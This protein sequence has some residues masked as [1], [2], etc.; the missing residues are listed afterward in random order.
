MSAAAALRAVSGLGTPRRCPARFRPSPLPR[1]GSV[2][3]CAPC[4]R[5]G[6]YEH[7]SASSLEA[8]ALSSARLRRAKPSGLGR[9]QTRERERIEALRKAAGPCQSRVGSRA[10][11]RLRPTARRALT[12]GSPPGAPPPPGQHART[13]GQAV[14][15]AT[16]TRWRRPAQPCRAVLPAPG[17][18][19]PRWTLW[20]EGTDNKSYKTFDC[21][22]PSC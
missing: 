16:R 13:R 20:K 12:G 5:A 9:V 3:G 17:I 21:A 11:R 6:G 4:E 7:H 8:K 18:L 19:S 1:P 2:R 10:G 14:P 22:S 15:A